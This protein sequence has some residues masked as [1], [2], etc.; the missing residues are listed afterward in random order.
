MTVTKQIY[1]GVTVILLSGLLMGTAEV[2]G[3]IQANTQ[4]REE[5]STKI[6]RILDTVTRMEERQKLLM[7]E[8]KKGR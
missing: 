4:H 1:I 6:E 5:S 3:D 8:Y 2:Y 7:D